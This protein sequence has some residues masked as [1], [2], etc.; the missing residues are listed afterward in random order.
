[1]TTLLPNIT[2]SNFDSRKETELLTSTLAVHFIPLRVGWHSSVLAGKLIDPKW[3]Q[4]GFYIF[5]VS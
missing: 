3:R 1:M 2:L 4:S 5:I